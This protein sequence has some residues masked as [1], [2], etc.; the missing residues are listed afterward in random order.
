MT[1]LRKNLL[2]YGIAIALP[3][4]VGGIAAALT[5]GNMDLYAQI[6]SPPLA[7]PAILFPIVWTVLYVLM[8]ISSAL[9]WQNR[10]KDPESAVT[11]LAYYAISLIFNFGWSLIFF[12][13]R[14]FGAA[15]LWLLILW[16]LILQTIRYYRKVSPLAAKLQI[17]YILWVSFAG[18]LNLAIWWL[19]R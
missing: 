11:G 9:V 19:N 5:A 17:P 18:Y 8:G 1:N 16:V 15:F 3:L 10:Q 4:A 13:A 7:P 2:L 12:N 6:Q 14:R